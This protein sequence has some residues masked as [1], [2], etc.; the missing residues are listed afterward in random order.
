M[1]RVRHAIACKL[2]EERWRPEQISFWLR[3]K[4]GIPLSHEWIYRMVWDNKRTGGNLWRFLRRRGKQYNRR[5][6]QYA[7]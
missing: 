1:R 4:Y 7:G 6:A 2:R 3:D 5:G